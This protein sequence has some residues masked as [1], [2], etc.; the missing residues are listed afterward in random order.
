MTLESSKTLAAIG[1]VLMVV[2]GASIVGLI[3][4]YL[5]LKELGEYYKDSRISG[6]DVI[7]GLVFIAIGAIICI[8]GIF[9]LFVIFANIF[10]GMIGLGLGLVGWIIMILGAG[11]VKK[12]LLS[13]AE[14]TG[15]NLFS[16]SAT[17]IR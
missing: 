12:T 4:M 13:L 17:T 14:R 6:G 11:R 3:L 7:I 1:S 16:T 10:L 5:G 8:S 9:M 2:P 15:E